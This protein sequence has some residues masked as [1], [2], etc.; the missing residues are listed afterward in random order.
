MRTEGLIY[1]AAIVIVLMG[2]VIA[3]QHTTITQ[4]VPDGLDTCEFSVVMSWDGGG[5]HPGYWVEL[6][7]NLERKECIM[8]ADQGRTVPVKD[9]A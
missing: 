4:P 9:P 1:V 7:N 8:R 6:D 5:A 3:S 2:A